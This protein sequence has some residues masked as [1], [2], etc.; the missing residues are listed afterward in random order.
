MSDRVSLLQRF[1]D[2]PDWLADR[3]Y[4]MNPVSWRKFYDWIEGGA[5]MPRVLED[6]MPRNFDDFI[7]NP[8]SAPESRRAEELA[9]WEA[10]K[11]IWGDAPWEVKQTIKP[12]RI[13]KWRD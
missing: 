13:R 1:G 9:K 4:A 2:V 11:E 3:V 6:T 7:A 5:P 12:P 10:W 8:H